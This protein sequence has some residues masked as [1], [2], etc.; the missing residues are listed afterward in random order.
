MRSQDDGCGGGASACRAASQPTS[1]LTGAVIDPRR[2]QL[3]LGLGAKSVSRRLQRWGVCRGGVECARAPHSI[4]R[5]AAPL[6]IL[7]GGTR[8]RSDT[9]LEIPLGR[10]KALASR[11]FQPTLAHHRR[12]LR[13]SRHFVTVSLL[14]HCEDTATLRSEPSR[15]FPQLHRQHAALSVISLDLAKS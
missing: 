9:D 4:R 1:V 5:V 2:A 14:S 13:T 11:L 12:I 10:I 8:K 6:S 15:I 7:A 3:Y